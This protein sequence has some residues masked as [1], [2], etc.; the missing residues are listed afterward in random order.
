MM[1]AILLRQAFLWMCEGESSETPNPL[2][3]G[4]GTREQDTGYRIQSHQKT[5]SWMPC[6]VSKNA[7]VVRFV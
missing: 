6:Y 4:G 5:S 1:L 7:I 2:L 3:F